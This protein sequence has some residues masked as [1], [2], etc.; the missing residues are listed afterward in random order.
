VLK[1]NVKNK[2]SSFAFQFLTIS[3]FLN[4]SLLF[5]KLRVV[6]LVVQL[7]INS[8]NKTSKMTTRHSATVAH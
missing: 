8:F 3:M 1:N 2:I 4:V 5:I 6:Q 7:L